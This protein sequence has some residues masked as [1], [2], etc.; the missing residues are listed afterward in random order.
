MVYRITK[1]DLRYVI[2][3]CKRVIEKVQPDVHPYLHERVRGDQKRTLELAYYLLD[4]AEETIDYD[5][6]LTEARINQAIGLIRAWDID[7]TE[8]FDERILAMPHSVNPS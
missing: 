5:K 7:P 6:I 2:G 8:G 1:S 4:Q 3:E